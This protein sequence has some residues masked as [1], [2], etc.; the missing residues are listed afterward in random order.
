MLDNTFMSKKIK[1][2]KSNKEIDDFIN[3]L[4][5]EE[6]KIIIREHIKRNEKEKDKAQYDGLSISKSAFVKNVHRTTL[7][8]KAKQRAYKFD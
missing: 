2:R 3:N 7:Y 4:T 5:D 1:K 6:K 8:K